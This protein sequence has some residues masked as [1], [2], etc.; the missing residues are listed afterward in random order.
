MTLQNVHVWIH[1]GTR[2]SDTDATLQNVHGCIHKGAGGLD[3]PPPPEKSQKLGFL[4]NTG[5]DPLKNHKAAK[6]ELNVGSS[7]AQQRNA[8]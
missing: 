6:P 8:I 3:R 2:S 4:S 7:S 5:P 1:R